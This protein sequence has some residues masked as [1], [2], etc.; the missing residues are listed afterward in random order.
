MSRKQWG[1]WS[2]IALA[3]LGVFAGCGGDDDDNSTNSNPPAG[4]ESDYQASGAVTTT[5]ESVISTE[6]GA[7]LQVPRYAVPETES[8]G[9]GTMVFSIE[10]N[11][12]A[13]PTPLSGHTRGSEV[14]R[15]GPDGFTFAEMVEITVPVLGDTTGKEVTLNRI[16]PNTGETEMVGGI[17]DPATN[18]ISAQ[19]YHLSDYFASLYGRNEQGWG[20]FKVTNASSTHWLSLCV[21]EYDLKYDDQEAFFDGNAQC[22]WAP[23]GTIGWSNSGDWFLPQ[24]DYTICVEMSR[25][26]TVSSPPGDPESWTIE[27]S[28]N[29][30]WSRLHSATTPITIG[31][32][33]GGATDG[34]CDCTPTPTT[35]VGTG[36]I[37]VTLTWHNPSSIDL[38][39]FVTEPN[40]TRCYYNHTPTSTGGTLDRDNKCSNYTNGR[41]E[42]IFWSSAPAGQYKVEVDWYSDCGN[43]M[44]SQSYDVRVVA[45]SSVRTYSGT[46]AKDQTVEVTTFTM[47]SAFAGTLP[48][49][50]G[51]PREVIFG[52]YSGRAV[53][54]TSKPDRKVDTE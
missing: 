46:I 29:S 4:N 22:Q 50:G 17:Y 34:P 20:A 7:E 13:A 52:E 47:T 54:S 25:A 42:N 27:A 10:R 51:S 32:V 37:Q 1:R 23:M 3:I 14:Y 35:S 40:G 49:G 31:S 11:A 28:L 8:G 26:G 53:P 24:G 21:E 30:P 19:R 5:Q 15:F 18:T 2:V 43:G 44:T 9:S 48:S 33:P 6:S 16:D 36:D 39:L 38:D 12:S 41:P 45:G